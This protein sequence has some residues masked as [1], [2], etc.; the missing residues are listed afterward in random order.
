MEANKS[1]YCYVIV[2]AKHNQFGAKIIHILYFNYLLLHIIWFLLDEIQ[3]YEKGGHY[4]NVYLGLY[5]RINSG[6]VKED[7]VP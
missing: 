7:C 4:K 3:F 5:F 6:V 1:D 2:M